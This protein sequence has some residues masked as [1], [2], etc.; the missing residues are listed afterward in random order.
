MRT[1]ETLDG[2]IELVATEALF[3]EIEESLAFWYAYRRHP[4]R[5]L[6]G[7]RRFMITTDDFRYVDGPRFW[8]FTREQ[9]EVMPRVLFPGDAPR[10]LVRFERDYPDVEAT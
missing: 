3:E 1:F 5:A 9:T 7:F 2:S 8:R 4:Y 6:G 10:I